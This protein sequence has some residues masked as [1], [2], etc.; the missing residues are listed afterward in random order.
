ME[1][2][3]ELEIGGCLRHERRT[4]HEEQRSNDSAADPHRASG[5]SARAKKDLMVKIDHQFKIEKII[6]P[7]GRDSRGATGVENVAGVGAEEPSRAN[8]E[9]IATRFTAVKRS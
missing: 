2:L 5:K 7:H 9:S 6:L 1:E 4:R 8:P 3:G